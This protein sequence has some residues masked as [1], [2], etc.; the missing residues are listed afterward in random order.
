MIAFLDEQLPKLKAMNFTPSPQECYEEN[1]EYPIGWNKMLGN[2]FHKVV[3]Q[4]VFKGRIL[5][6]IPYPVCAWYR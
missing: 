5:Y 3:S 4:Y 1:K 6:T 2:I